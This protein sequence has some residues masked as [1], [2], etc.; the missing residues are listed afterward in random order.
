MMNAEIKPGDMF[1]T[2]GYNWVIIK[3]VYISPYNQE[4]CYLVKERDGDSEFLVFGEELN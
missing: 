4:R 3:N 1:D 2:E